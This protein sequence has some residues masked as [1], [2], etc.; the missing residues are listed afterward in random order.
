[1]NKDYISKSFLILLVFA[2]LGA[3][4]LVFRPFLPELIMATVLASVFY[5]P[6]EWLAKKLGNQKNLASLL[7]CIFIL[8]IIIIPVANLIV[9][10]ANKTID[11]Y[12]ESASF[13]NEYSIDAVK[14]D[15]SRLIK[16]PGLESV[17][18]SEVALSVTK[19]FSFWLYEQLAKIAIGATSLLLVLIAV[20][21]FF[22]DG[23]VLLEKLMY[24]TP[25]PNKYDKAI[26][27]KFRDVSYSIM[28]SIFLV[29]I[30]QGIIGAIG[31]MIA[32][33]PAF[34]PGIFMA[35]ASLLPYFGASLIWLPASIY[36]LTIGNIWQGIFLIIW[37]IIAVSTSDN[38]IRTYLIKDKAQ[39]HPLFIFFSILGG[40]TLFGF[41]GII[42]GPLIIS[43][44]ITIFHIYE[45][46]YTD[47]LEK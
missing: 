23:K 6:Y 14:S 24:W 1:M 29:G 34:F 17:N 21:F 42:F 10:G 47:V 30:A 16:L 31:F 46:E 5:A 7:M 28:V 15:L 22:I 8:L 9:F 33:L 4:Y 19:N 18:L 43:L 11:A 38:I 37:G 2:V 26:F 13:I 20:Y 45:M 27:Q 41:W 40:L 35:I 36:L 25:L 3:C 39:V 44:T 32:G 12:N